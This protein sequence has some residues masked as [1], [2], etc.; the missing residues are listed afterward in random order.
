MRERRTR[1][2]ERAPSRRLAEAQGPSITIPVI[3]GV[4]GRIV[5]VGRDR[6]EPDLADRDWANRD[7]A[8]VTGPD[9]GAGRVRDRPLLRSGP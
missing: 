4:T 7:E 9:D 2:R 6:A 1:L 8:G 5:I 3:S